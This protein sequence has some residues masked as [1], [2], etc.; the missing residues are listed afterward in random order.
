MSS[1]DNEILAYYYGFN[2]KP[3]E[4]KKKCETN[5]FIKNNSKSIFDIGAYGSISEVCLKSDCKYIVKLIPLSHQK[6]YKTFLREALIAPLMA[7]NGIGPKIYDIFVCLNAGYI[8]MEKWDG[9]IRKLTDNKLFTDKHLIKICDKISKMNDLGVIHG[10][11][12]TAN[13]LFRIKNNKYEFCITDFGLSLYFE[14][15]NSIIPK[16]FIPSSKLPNIFFPAFDFH[17]FSGALESRQKIIFNPLFFNKGYISYIDYII[18]DKFYRKGDFNNTSFSDFIKT[19]NINIDNLQAKNT[20]NNSITLLNVLENRK[21]LLNKPLPNSKNKSIK[22]ENNL[23]IPI[24]KNKSIKSS[25]N[26]KSSKTNKNLNRNSNISELNSS[27][28]YSNI[29]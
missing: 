22:S 14:D 10:D 21:S 12:H 8:I 25:K 20:I 17:R 5:Y 6:I 19:L 29:K 16:N 24:N 28:P 27:T 15:K 3:M 4:I 23:T 26:R 9:S 11:L 13:V 18:V 1:I 7:K 2:E